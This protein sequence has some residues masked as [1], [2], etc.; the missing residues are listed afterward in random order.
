MKKLLILTTLVFTVMFSS[1]SFAECKNLSLSNDFL[2]PY[3]TETEKW[4]VSD[5]FYYK[6]PKLGFSI[7]L[8]TND[9]TV[10]FYIFDLGIKN[11]TDNMV[12]KLLRQSVSEMLQ[13]L[14]YKDTLPTSEPRLLPKKLF[15]GSEE[16]LIHNAVYVVQE[17]KPE[18][19]VSIVSI[20]FDGSCFQKLRFTK[21]LSSKDIDIK[22][23]FDNPTHNAEIL[24]S[25]LQFSGF[26]KI[27]NE[28][29]YRTGYYK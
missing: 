9:S 20:G 24:A 23:Y 25:I 11:F 10:N 27:L 3:E 6:D 18:N 12:G 4:K 19:I 5:T 1:T 22:T 2:A 7:K 28:E 21:D 15:K 17:R 16:H 13:V 26:V 29:L 14:N 8:K